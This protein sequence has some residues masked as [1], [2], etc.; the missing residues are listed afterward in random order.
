MPNFV[1]EQWIGNQ[2]MGI[3]IK[4]SDSAYLLPILWYLSTS[5]HFEMPKIVDTLD[6]HAAEFIILGSKAKMILDNWTF[7]IGF[8]NPAVRDQVITELRA[9]PDNYFAQET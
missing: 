4:P 2:W 7:S 9:L 3:E 1:E 5:Y 8:E 6:G